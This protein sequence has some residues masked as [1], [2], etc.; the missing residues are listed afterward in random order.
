MLLEQR[1]D[2]VSEQPVLTLDV[3]RNAHRFILTSLVLRQH[4]QQHGIALQHSLHPDKRLSGSVVTQAIALLAVA[5]FY[6]SLQPPNL[7]SYRKS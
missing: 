3:H 7:K 2:L 6:D 4:H 5:Y 1:Y